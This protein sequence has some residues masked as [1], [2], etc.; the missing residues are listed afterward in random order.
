MTNSAVAKAIGLPD[1]PAGFIRTLLL[2]YCGHKLFPVR[3]DARR[4]MWCYDE[5]TRVENLDVT[6]LP[7]RLDTESTQYAKTL[8]HFSGTP[9]NNQQF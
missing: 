2:R 1:A 9:Q 3:Y 8:K 5:A 7:Q 4:D 6:E